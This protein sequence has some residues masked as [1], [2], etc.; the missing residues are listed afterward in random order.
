MTAVKSLL[1][2]NTGPRIEKGTVASLDGG[3]GYNR[4]GVSITEPQ[5]DRSADMR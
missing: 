1:V 4:T 3:G 2:G 5:R